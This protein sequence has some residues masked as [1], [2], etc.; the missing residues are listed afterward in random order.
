MVQEALTNG[1]K[2]ADATVVTIAIAEEAGRIELRVADDGRGFDPEAPSE[3]FGLLGMRER[4]ALVGG[5]LTVASR[6]GGGTAI[7]TQ[8]PLGAATAPA[9]PRRHRC[10]RPGRSPA[11]RPRA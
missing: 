4:A 1:V 6:L 7:R 10:P 9:A 3:G 5:E 2:H 8:L 11:A